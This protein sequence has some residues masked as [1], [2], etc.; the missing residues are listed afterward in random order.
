MVYC[1]GAIPVVPTTGELV[2]GSIGDKTERCCENLKAILTEAGSSLEK[3][4]KVG[5]AYRFLFISR[6]EIR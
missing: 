2:D 3:V 5:S 1:S 4:V 6:V